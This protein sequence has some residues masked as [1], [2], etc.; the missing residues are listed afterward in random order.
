M[1]NNKKYISHIIYHTAIITILG[2][3]ILFAETMN[4][5]GDI[6][7]KEIQ[8]ETF[9][10]IWDKDSENRW[11][12]TSLFFSGSILQFVS[13]DLGLKNQINANNTEVNFIGGIGV[14]LTYIPIHKHLAVGT[15]IR[16]LYH[17]D[18]RNIDTH[19]L[20][21]LA[22]LH[23]FPYIPYKL[24]FNPI[25]LVFGAGWILCKKELEYANGVYIEAGIAL[26]KFF[27]VNMEVLYR[28]S[29]YNQYNSFKINNIT[30][31][32]NV[33]FSIF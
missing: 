7:N 30:H 24:G 21:L 33:V 26:F 14:G 18:G 16:Y 32:V 13:V 8:K 2:M 6:F 23:P 11:D 22:Y 9:K 28:A 10:N 27:P 31:S 1:E 4:I 17:S 12:K 19:S 15:R 5:S 3:Q 20:G 29:F 25:S